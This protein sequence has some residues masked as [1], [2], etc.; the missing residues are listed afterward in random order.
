MRV[1]SIILLLLIVAVALLLGANEG[2]AQKKGKGN[3]DPVQ[4]FEQIAQ[5]RNFVFVSEMGSM[6]LAQWAEQKGIRDGK[7]TRDMYMDYAQTFSGGRGPGGSFGGP[8][9]SFGGPSGFGG[10]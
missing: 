4:R 3:F 9:G 2:L 1:K 10:R 8:G 6:R 7:I 5:G